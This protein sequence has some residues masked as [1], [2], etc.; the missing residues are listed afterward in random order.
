[1][2]TPDDGLELALADVRRY[3]ERLADGQLILRLV[4]RDRVTMGHDLAVDGLRPDDY[5]RLMREKP[6]KGRTAAVP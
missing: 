2:L 4:R 6:R 3:C 5:D 1:M